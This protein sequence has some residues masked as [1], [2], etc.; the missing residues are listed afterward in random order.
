MS[1]TCFLLGI[2]GAIFI[3]GVLPVTGKS[4]KMNVGEEVKKRE[5]ER[6][7]VG[8]ILLCLTESASTFSATKTPQ[9]IH[10]TPHLVVTVPDI[11]ANC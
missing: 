6:E 7:K 1:L 5:R 10:S 9:T 2:F 3:L 11:S 4:E 8:D